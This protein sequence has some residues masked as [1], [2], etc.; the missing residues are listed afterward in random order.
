MGSNFFMKDIT[1]E[2][3]VSK[4]INRVYMIAGAVAAIFITKRL[5]TFLQGLFLSG[6]GNAIIAERQRRFMTAWRRASL[7]IIRYRQPI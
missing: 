3:V 1:D 4:D 7:S 6:V 5:A 2:F